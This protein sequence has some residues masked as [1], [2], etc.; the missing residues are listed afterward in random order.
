MDTWKQFADN[1]HRRSP[2]L[3]EI[4]NISYYNDVLTQRGI[5]CYNILISGRTKNDGDKIKGLNEYIN[6][7]NQ[8]HNEK[9]PKLQ[10]LYKQI[11][12]DAESASFKVDIIENDKELL[13]M[14]PNVFVWRRRW[15]RFLL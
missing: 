1:R 13:T 10:E 8:T 5:E 2:C 7:F 4:F 6:E 11:L 12:S 14:L 9:I 15:K 3:Y